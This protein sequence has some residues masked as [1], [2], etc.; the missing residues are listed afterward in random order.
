MVFLKHEKERGNKKIGIRKFYLLSKG[1]CSD[2]PIPYDFKKNKYSDYVSDLENIKLAYINYP[3]GRLVRNKLIFSYFFN[4]YFKTPESFCT[5]DNGKIQ[6]V[7]IKP[8]I[9]SLDKLIGLA[10]QRKLILKPLMGT[11]GK[12]IILFEVRNN[13]ELLLNKKPIHKRNFS[14]FIKSLNTYL[15]T[16]YVE[17]GDFSNRFF[18]DT[19]N[20]I[21]LTTF[22]DSDK[23]LPFIPYSFM[24][25]G[26]KNSIPADNI[27][28]GGIFSMIDV[29]TGELTAAFE[30]VKFKKP[31]LLE[32]HPDTSE[33]IKGVVI[34]GW[35]QLKEF[36][37]NLGKI[38]NPFIK[39]V[40]WDIILTDDSFVVLEG[41]NGPNLY[42]NQ[43][44]GYPLAKIPEVKKFLEYHKIR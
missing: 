4:S 14:E 19:A 13:T 30:I 34:P 40:G 36:F 39:V 21:R 28:Q 25:F 2:H 16:E 7:R 8:Y 43:G 11:G 41:N 9:D 6:P 37:I 38:I 29:K 35:D 26:R 10:Q 22:Y 20:T 12:G 23:S 24:R 5:I 17:Q 18:P 31:N 15:V 33:P 42:N 3:Y 32:R 1:F 44:A 27:S